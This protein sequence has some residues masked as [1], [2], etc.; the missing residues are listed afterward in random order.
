MLATGIVELT[1]SDPGAD[2]KP[3]KA[4]RA[5]KTGTMAK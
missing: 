5:D 1:I 3:M 2:H 4:I